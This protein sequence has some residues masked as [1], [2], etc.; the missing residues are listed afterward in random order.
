MS[1]I[2]LWNDKS[3][4]FRSKYR[5]NQTPDISVPICLHNLL[6]NK[7]IYP[8]QRSIAEAKQQVA[9]LAAVNT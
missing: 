3:D 5:Q 8:G 6:L 2:F 7:Q 1:I 4:L 9:L